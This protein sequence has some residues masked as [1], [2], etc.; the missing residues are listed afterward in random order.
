MRLR[1]APSP[2]GFLHVG[3]ARTALFNWLLAK[4]HKGTFV[5]RIEDTDRS[6]SS[7]EMTTAILEGM[8]WLELMWD[9]GPYHQADGFDRHKAEA[10]RMLSDGKAYR[11]FCTQE[12]VEARKAAAPR[13]SKEAF[14]YDR[15]C[16]LKV[17]AEDSERRAATGEKFAIR[18][19]VPA[20]K[21]SWQDAV[22]GATEF[23]NAD[24]DDFIILRSDGTPIYNLAVVSDDIEHRIT[25]VIRGDDHI[26]NT[27][28]QILIYQALE[29]QPPTFAHVPMILGPDGKRLSKRHGATAVGEYKDYGILPDAMV[30][31][32]ALLGWAPGNDE[33]MLT[34][35]EMIERFSLEAINKKS[36]VFDTAKL[37]WMNGQYLA[38]MSAEELE[39]L[40][41]EQ[42]SSHAT[43]VAGVWLRELI[44]LLKIRA[45][46]V[47]GIAEQVVP[48]LSD[49]VVYDED[50]VQKQ[51]KH[52]A[53]AADRI[54]KV[55]DHLPNTDAWTH[56][57]LERSLRQL[58]ERE[59]VG[60]GKLIHP[61]RVAVVGNSASPGIFDVMKL[62]GRERTL[63]RIDDALAQL[64][65]MK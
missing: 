14:H 41:R 33:E 62:L 20:G 11:C 6:R 3:G 19:K 9:E 10:L 47:T 31:F 12:E 52:P 24:I 27:P 25:H 54:Q 53:E 16:L 32:L 8:K 61:L 17:S 23:D 64:A 60:A 45:R 63:R 7:D 15:H 1:F 46:T 48:Y 39:P 34:R 13:E 49:P 57:D 36:A 26:S 2:T 42:L 50:A 65:Q 37:E 35:A 44:D 28:K 4:K 58:A 21:T 18:F 29:Q 22:H 59:G 38:R 43:G 55:R 5:L 51:W 40:V 30:N 56:D